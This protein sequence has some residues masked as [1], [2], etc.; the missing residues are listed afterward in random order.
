MST[1]KP[2]LVAGLPG[3]FAGG[4]AGLPGGLTAGG[5]PLPM[6][7][8]VSGLGGNKKVDGSNDLS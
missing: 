7:L 3:G 1:L 4:S 2:G 8:P 5:L 6:T